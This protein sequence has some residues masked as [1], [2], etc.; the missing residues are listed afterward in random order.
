MRKRVLH[1]GLFALFLPG[2]GF[3]QGRQTKVYYDD[4]FNLGSQALHQSKTRYFQILT[5]PAR[6]DPDGELFRYWG[7]KLDDFFE[8]VCDNL[9]LTNTEVYRYLLYPQFFAQLEELVLAGSLHPAYFD[10]IL[11]LTI[12]VSEGR[13][14]PPAQPLV[15]AQPTTPPNKVRGPPAT[16]TREQRWE[17]RHVEFEGEKVLVW[18]PRDAVRSYQRCVLYRTLSDFLATPIGPPLPEGV[19]GFV[20]R[21]DPSLPIVIYASLGEYRLRRT[22]QHEIAHAVVE[23]IAKYLRGLAPM[24]TRHAK[25]DTTTL[26]RAWRRSSGGFSAI[27]HENYAEY[28]AFPHGQ[29][30]PALRAAL[31]EMVAENEL[32]GLAALSVGARTL[33]SSYIEGPARL[34]FLAERF[35]RDLPKK[36]LVSYYSQTGGFLD[37]LEELTGQPVS[38]LE[39]LYRRWLREELWQE[40]LSTDI[41]DT[42]GTVMAHGLAGVRRDGELLVQL[43]RRGRQEIVLRTPQERGVRERH[44]VRDLDDGI[45]R[46]PIFSTP[47]LHQGR[48][49][50][51]VRSRNEESL[52]LWDRKRGGRIRRLGEL[53]PVREVRDPRWS[54]DGSAIVFR[55]VERSGRNAIGYLDVESNEAHLVTPWHW[56][57]IAS[58]RFAE[59]PSLVVFTST[60][61]PNYE[62]DVFLL[63]LETGETRNLTSSPDIAE[64]EPLF[65]NGHL[66]YLSDEKGVPAPTEHLPG[67]GNRTLMTLPFPVSRMQL[68]DSTLTLVANSLRHSRQPA[69]RAVWG[70]PLAK[71]GLDVSTPQPHPLIALHDDALPGVRM[72]A[73]PTADPEPEPAGMLSDL[74]HTSGYA[75]VGLVVSPYKQKWRFMPLGLNLTSSSTRTNGATFMGF[76]TEF[77]DQSVMFAVGQSGEFDRFGLI[78]YANRASR[79]HWQVS[80]FYRSILRARFQAD[81]TFSVNRTESEQGLLLSGQYHQSLVSRVGLALAVT[82]RTDTEGKILASESESTVLAA[83]APVLEMQMPRLDPRAWRLALGGVPNVSLL[84]D[85]SATAMRQWAEADRAHAAR[86]EREFLP[87]QEYVRPNAEVGLSFSR[88]TRVWSDARGP[89]AGSL[90]LVSVAS[91]FNAPG[92]RTELN[93]AKQDSV[94][95]RVTAGLNRVSFAALLVKHQRLGH[96][97]LAFRGRALLNDG[98]QAL[99][100]GLGGM[101]SVSGYPTGFIRSERIA[102]A[103]FEV[104]AQIWDYSRLRLPVYA[105]TL[106]ATDAFIF[107]DA[108]IA[109]G[110]P[111]I[112]SYGVGVRLRLGF[113]AYEWRHLIRNGL[114]NQNGLVLVW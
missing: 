16:S 54:P 59:D 105:L 78:Q 110:A 97:D 72:A 67:G 65:V 9:Q 71:L 12:A 10:S 93:G 42:L 55:V 99:I 18:L 21:H 100:Y 33:A 114:R 60:A 90:W 94:Q 29:M 26:Q 82:R 109:E 46:I 101:Y 44:V 113:L 11:H 98:P 51:S 58:P 106:P 49:V 68:S 52:F 41:A 20:P 66:V 7:P 25:R 69:S 34:F 47:D 74:R 39:R 112:Y 104:R 43:V 87:T 107:Y 2:L 61:T 32:D 91:G 13:A 77:H 57:E 81:S 111:A 62:S 8:R 53:G 6:E 19:L 31:V 40:H 79:I 103:N 63:D 50:T 30:E 5:T 88:D 38:T 1:V 85:R 28:L 89:R 3:A 80:G 35:G 27:T 48:V 64:Q 92:M 75:D 73:A 23:N 15:L 45:E 37:R 86:A 102:Y 24:R 14:T 95:H 83:E 36:L 84:T 70:F 56:A 96:L 4:L 108:G 22:A 76:D 17:T